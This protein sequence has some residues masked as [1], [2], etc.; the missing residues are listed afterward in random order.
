MGIRHA[1]AIAAVAVLASSP[2]RGGAVAGAHAHDPLLTRSLEELGDV[3]VR[4][5]SPRAERLADAPA[6]VF[7]IHRDEIRALGIHSL[8][9]ALRLAPNLQVAQ[10]NA[11]SHAVTAR[12]L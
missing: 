11:A 10:L 8:P 7:V 1:V 12:G 5:A 3:E 6:S 2:A 9:E 4:T